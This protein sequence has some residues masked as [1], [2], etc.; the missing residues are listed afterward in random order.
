MVNA[1]NLDSFIERFS[2]VLDVRSS[3]KVNKCPKV[4]MNNRLTIQAVIILMLLINGGTLAYASPNSSVG[5]IAAGVGEASGGPNDAAGRVRVTRESRTATGQSV[6]LIH[7]N[8][9]MYPYIA[10]KC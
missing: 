2:G 5:D 9:S 8:V 3:L 6:Q 7:R 10:A 4:T 1:R